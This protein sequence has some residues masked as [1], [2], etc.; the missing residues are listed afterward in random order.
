M[1]FL[2][3]LHNN[4]ILFVVAYRM[5]SEF[6]SIELIGKFLHELLKRTFYRNFRLFHFYLALLV[7]TN[8]V[9]ALYGGIYSGMFPEMV[10]YQKSKKIS[11]QK[12]LRS[13]FS[14]SSVNYFLRRWKEKQIRSF[15]WN[16]E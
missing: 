16:D 12:L 4:T 10:Q 6:L 11:T 9:M 13:T 7:F 3:N 14:N 5:T 8:C 1:A 15:E 2:L